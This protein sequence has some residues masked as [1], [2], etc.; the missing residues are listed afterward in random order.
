MATTEPIIRTAKAGDELAAI[1]IT[2]KVFAPYSV[3]HI[4]ETKLGLPAGGTRWIV[5][6]AEVIRR[7]FAENPEGCF[8]AEIDGQM[9]G[10]VSTTV[11]RV[12]SRG[13]I[14]NLAVLPESQGSGLGRKLLDRAIEY[15]RGLGLAQAK[16]ETLET[17]PVGQHLY[18]AVGFEEVVRQIHYVM[19]LDH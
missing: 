19:P 8:V 6:K 10:Y 3:D 15:F 7:E 11:N 14:A 1:A 2:E 4:I 18:P 13:I 12:A 16:I 9:A 5:V 17:N